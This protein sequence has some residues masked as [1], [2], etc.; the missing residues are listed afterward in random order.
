[1]A[2][3]DAGESLARQRH[4]ETVGVRREAGRRRCTAPCEEHN[5]GF[6]ALGRVHGVDSAS[7]LDS[8]GRRE[9]Y[10]TLPQRGSRCSRR[11]D[12]TARRRC[13]TCA[14]Y[15][16]NTLTWRCC[17]APS[18]MCCKIATHATTSA[19]LRS[20]VAMRR[21]GSACSDA[22]SS[23]RPETRTRT[24]RP[25]WLSK[26]PTGDGQRSSLQH[27]GASPCTPLAKRYPKW[28]D[29]S[30]AGGSRTS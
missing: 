6:A 17:R 21:F 20:D 18:N 8:T 30:G 26:R 7:E 10:S 13:A 24:L 2:D 25:N 29:P 23:D 14:R 15:S 27:H 28:L 3:D 5:I 12:S 4:V 22:P 11:A 16:D 19:S 1:M 9:T